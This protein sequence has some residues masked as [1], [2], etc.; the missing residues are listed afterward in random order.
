[1]FI[2]KPGREWKY[3]ACNGKHSQIERRHLSSISKAALRAGLPG[4][5]FRGVLLGLV[6]QACW[7]EECALH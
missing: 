7:G 5:V 1:M 3:Y 4:W 2:H 6:N